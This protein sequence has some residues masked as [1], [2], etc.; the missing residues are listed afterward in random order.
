MEL[1]ALLRA[2]GFMNVE[3]PPEL[4]EIE[5]QDERF[6]PM[7][8]EM[9]AIGLGV[10]NDLSD[11]TLAVS[12]VVV[13]PDDDQDEEPSIDPGDYVAVTVKG[14]GDWGDDVWHP[15]EGPTKGLL[16]NVAPRADDAGATLAYARDLGTE[17]GAVTV[18]LPRS[19]PV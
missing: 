10:G 11:L 5:S 12:N 4:W 16:V 15:G 14:P 7:L 17:G 18:F 6:L 2:H 8:G 13:S 3:R 9:I 1:E 19:D